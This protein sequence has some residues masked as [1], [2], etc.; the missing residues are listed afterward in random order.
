MYRLLKGLGMSESVVSS[1]FSMAGSDSGNASARV[2][3]SSTDRVVKRILIG[4]S[5]V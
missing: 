4:N 5:M 2:D 1:R 3:R